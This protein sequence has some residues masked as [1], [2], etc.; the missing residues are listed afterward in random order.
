MYPRGC[1]T[2]YYKGK[3]KVF[4]NGVQIKDAA[5]SIQDS[6]VYGFVRRTW[7]AGNYTVYYIQETWSPNDV[8]D[9][10]FRTLLPKEVDIKMTSF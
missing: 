7:S 6:E 3:M 4:R 9:Y 10:S 8:R 2:W 1:K 5:K